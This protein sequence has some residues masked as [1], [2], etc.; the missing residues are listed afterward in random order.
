M[1]NGTDIQHELDMYIS[2]CQTL[3]FSLEENADIDLSA[4]ERRALV[5]GLAMGMMNIDHS[6]DDRYR[7]DL[8]EA[9]ALY[10]ARYRA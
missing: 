5:V 1:K 2:A 4:C 8:S 3:D 6:D 10:D 9:L 7:Y